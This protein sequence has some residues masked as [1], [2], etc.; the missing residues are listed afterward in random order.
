MLCT[1]PPRKGLVARDFPASCTRIR[2][3]LILDRAFL[4]E[5]FAFFRVLLTISRGNRVRDGVFVCKM[6]IRMR[7]S[8][9]YY[10]AH[11]FQ[12][13]FSWPAFLLFPHYSILTKCSKIKCY[14]HFC[15]FSESLSDKRYRRSQLCQV[16]LRSI[17]RLL[18]SYTYADG[19]NVLPKLSA[20]L[21]ITYERRLSDE[22]FGF[23][24]HE[25]VEQMLSVKA[26]QRIFEERNDR[27][28]SKCR[29]NQ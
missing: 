1:P 17:C 28:H 20:W 27:A 25:I 11:L 12:F 3:F 5:I 9:L 21:A 2:I 13:S 8:S 6:G 15:L 26:E 14:S 18:K 29:K 24:I 10:M 19:I 7:D 22:A 16:L 4:P 23:L